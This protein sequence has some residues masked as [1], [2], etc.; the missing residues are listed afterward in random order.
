MDCHAAA[1][2]D[3]GPARLV[4]TPGA[5]HL[6]E[7]RR[8]KEGTLEEPHQEADDAGFPGNEIEPPTEKA[9]TLS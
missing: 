2:R 1:L 8:T 6:S 9:L 7:E 4:L 5:R 3:P